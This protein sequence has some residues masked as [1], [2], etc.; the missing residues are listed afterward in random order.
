MF[1]EKYTKFQAGFLEFVNSLDN[2]FEN[3]NTILETEENIDDLDYRNL[4]INLKRLNESIF[5]TSKNKKTKI[6]N[7][8][9]KIAEQISI[10]NNSN[11]SGFISE[12]SGY[13]RNFVSTTIN[14]FEFAYNESLI[15]YSKPNYGSFWK[16]VSEWIEGIKDTSLTKVKRSSEITLSISKT[17]EISFEEYLKSSFEEFANNQMKEAKYKIEDTCKQIE[18]IFKLNEIDGYPIPD[19]NFDISAKINEI[20]SYSVRIDSPYS[21]NYPKV[22]FKSLIIEIRSYSMMFILLVSTL[23]LNRG[24]S[25]TMR[26]IIY[27]VSMTL[28][29]IGVGATYIKVQDNKIEK[30]EDEVKKAREKLLA[31]AKRALMDFTNDWKTHLLYNFKASM[32]FVSQRTEQFIKEYAKNK[33]ET[34]V[35]AKNS[36]GQQLQILDMQDR[37]LQE[38]VRKCDTFQ[39][40]IEILQKDL[41]IH[42]KKLNQ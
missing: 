36:L 40:Q 42:Y 13:V 12:I 3:L 10:Y 28:I 1:V 31:E 15:R 38:I 27:I 21:G 23:G 20:I 5:E 9:N 2:E 8:K 34:I 29:A 6:A 37:A 7:E 39:S 30:L 25:N 35:A 17:V 4:I 24:Q 16:P 11:S 26:V 41:E 32:T 33:N 19:I 22:N 14:S 18:E